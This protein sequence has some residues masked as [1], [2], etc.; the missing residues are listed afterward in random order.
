MW[1]AYLF[2]VY[3]LIF[4]YYLKNKKTM[5]IYFFLIPMFL[6]LAFQVGVGT[7][8]ELYLG[9]V[10]SPETFSIKKGIL[11]KKLL[12]ILYLIRKDQIL[13]IIISGIQ[14]SLLYLVLKKLLKLNIIGNIYSYFIILVIATPIYYQ[15]FNTLRSSVASLLFGLAFINLKKRFKIFYLVLAYLIHPS[16]IIL[17]PVVLIK[18]KLNFY[19]NK[20]ILVIYLVFCFIFMKTKTIYKISNFIY[21]LDIDFKYKNYLISTHMFRYKETLGI[22]ISIQ[23]LLFL[24]FVFFIYKNQKNIVMINLGIITFGM[25]LL[26]YYTPVLNRMLEYFNIFLGLVIYQLIQKTLKKKYCYLG[27]IIFIFYILCFL[28]QSTLML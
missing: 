9:W 6:S 12:E 22:A 14:V 15:M 20:I 25:S 5:Y 3:I 28:R 4:W 7:D 11:F 2:L 27:I 10:K 16:V 13:F 19:I 1:R 8:Y 21:N 23:F 18:Q 26:L 24:F 17:T